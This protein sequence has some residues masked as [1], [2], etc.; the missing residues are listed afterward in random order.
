M[1]LFR[2]NL[3][4]S[5]GSLL[6]EF[7]L[8]CCRI[9]GVSKPLADFGLAKKNKD[10]RDNQC[11][12]CKN[13]SSR[14]H[15]NLNSDRIKSKQRKSYTEN[16]IRKDSSVRN[17]QHN[18]PNKVKAHRAVN[19]AVRYGKLKSQPCECCGMPKTRAHHDDYLQPLKVRWLCAKHHAEWHR[20][21]GEAL[22]GK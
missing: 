3:V 11:K 15:Y 16:K 21:N 2:S 1:V 5:F 19:D 14:N 10:G 6:L 17:Y 13:T 7:K 20:I 4:G 12:V 9:C 18:F 22:N 8:K